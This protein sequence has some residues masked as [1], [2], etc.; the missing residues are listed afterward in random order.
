MTP[1]Q[2]ENRGLAWVL[3]AF[4][5]CPCHLPLTLSAIA[6][7]LSGTAAGALLREHVYVA[8]TAVTAIW[9]AATWRGIRYLR[10]ATRVCER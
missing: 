3:G 4:V 2:A 8:G 1:G 7:L 6:A 9:A 10:A 5:F